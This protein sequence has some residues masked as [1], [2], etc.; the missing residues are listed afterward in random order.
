MNNEDFFG[1]SVFRQPHSLVVRNELHA[2]RLASS[3]DLW[4]GG[5]GAFE[6][7]IRLYRPG[8]WWQQQS[9]K[10]LGRQRGHAIS[11]RV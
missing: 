7:N 10:C 4:Y 8:D 3:Q 5:G 9:R 2:L 11:L 1:T 6:P